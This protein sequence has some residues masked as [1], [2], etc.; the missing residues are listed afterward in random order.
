MEH[1]DIYAFFCP[2]GNPVSSSIEE[3]SSYLKTNKVKFG[4]LWI[5]V[6]PASGS[7][8]SS[9]SENINYV[10]DIAQALV[11]AGIEIGVYTSIATW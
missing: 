9:D 1:V 10:A 3:I 2:T 11:K 7:W 4:R 6:E 8:T 5:D